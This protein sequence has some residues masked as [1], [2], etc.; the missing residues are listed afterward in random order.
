MCFDERRFRRKFQSRMLT[1]QVFVGAASAANRC[2]CYPLSRRGEGG[3]KRSTASFP[4]S[5]TRVQAGGWMR[6]APLGP[7]G[8][9]KGIGNK[10]RE[11]ETE[12]S[13]PARRYGISHAS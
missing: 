5:A 10:Q 11:P 2:Y 6:P 4:R 12:Q 7:S 3:N 8:E 9:D 13:P 1:A